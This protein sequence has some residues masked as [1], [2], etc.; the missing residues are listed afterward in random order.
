MNQP[1]S[2]QPSSRLRRWLGRGVAAAVAT[3]LLL[4]VGATGCMERH[5]YQPSPGDT[6][7]PSHLAAAESVWFQSADGT[8]LHGW[9]IPA[10]DGTPPAEAPTILHV[11]GNAGNIELH[12]W[13]TEH[14][15]PAG[16]NLFI[17]DYRGYGRSEGA[18]RR[19]RPLIDDTHAAVDVLL[20][21]SDIDATRL[22]MYAQSLGGA[23]GLNVMARRPQLRAAVIESAFTSWREMAASAVGGDPP[24]PVSRFF[25]GLLIRD[26]H[27]PADA[28]AS[29]DR[30]ILLIHGSADSIIPVGHGRRL[31]AAG[32]TVEFVE[33]DGGDHNSLRSSHP[34][35]DGLMIEF[36]RK[37]LGP[38]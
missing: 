24:G 35:I 15:P 7:P 20:A 25:A 38:Q 32:P 36:F 6:I 9:L 18:A 3:A 27:R 34:E 28:I 12:V 16:F 8:R 11:H 13:F 2:K 37:Q 29:I 17:F 1:P 10:A 4:G 30:P 5:F 23:I 14:L 22:G 21:R 31:A 33:L 19:R 26:D